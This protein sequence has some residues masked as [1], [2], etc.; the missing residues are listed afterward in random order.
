[1][2][3]G[4]EGAFEHVAVRDNAIS[5]DE[6]TAAARKLFTVRVEGFNRDRGRL[7]AADEFRKNIL[8]LDF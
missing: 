6:K 2:Y 3:L 4:A 8:R 7:N 1:M 5:L